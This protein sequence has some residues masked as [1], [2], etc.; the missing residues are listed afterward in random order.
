MTPS[1]PEYRS[2]FTTEERAWYVWDDYEIED[3]Q[4][5][6]IG[7]IERTRSYDALAYPELVEEFVRLN[8]SDERALLGYVRKWGLLGASGA[9]EMQVGD[10]RVGDHLSWVWLSL[11]HAN[12]LV[13]LAML[14][15]S[16]DDEELRRELDLLAASY[17]GD[18]N[19]LHLSRD[20]AARGGVIHPFR[21]KSHV[22]EVISSWETPKVI[23]WLSS[24]QIELLD[25]YLRGVGDALTM[26][27]GGRLVRTKHYGPLVNVIFDSLADTAVGNNE[28]SRCRRCRRF[29]QQKH[30]NQRYCPPVGKQKES[31]CALAARQATL[32]ASKR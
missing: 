25:P 6:P 9:W 10:S 19:F 32:R 13:A 7:R 8:P 18:S 11:E 5:M 17:V 12:L 24:I 14:K 1:S 28:Y 21:S 16:N 27:D 2:F 3:Y 22:D 29:F 26:Q 15:K 23:S 30:G 20:P 31:S 4:V